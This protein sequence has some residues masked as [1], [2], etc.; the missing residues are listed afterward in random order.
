MIRQRVTDCPDV[1]LRSPHASTH[2]QTCLCTQHAHPIHIQNKHNQANRTILATAHETDCGT[3]AVCPELPELLPSLWQFIHPNARV[4]NPA[5][6]A[7]TL[8]TPLISELSNVCF[9]Y[10]HREKT[11]TPPSKDTC[12]WCSGRQENGNSTDTCTPS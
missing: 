5:C 6:S 2:T 12:L 10:P 7:Y 9:L 11:W 3:S 1:I 4:F 8:L